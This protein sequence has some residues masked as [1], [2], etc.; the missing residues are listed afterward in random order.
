MK[1]KKTVK[2]IF[3]NLLSLVLMACFVTM[4]EAK[5]YTVEEAKAVIMQKCDKKAQCFTL[6][7]KLLL[8]A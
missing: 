6:K 2:L 3:S 7:D 4:V 1:I 5:S 8:I